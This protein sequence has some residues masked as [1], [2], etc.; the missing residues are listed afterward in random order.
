MFHRLGIAV[1]S[2]LFLVSAAAGETAA[3]KK[4]A[5]SRTAPPP[6]AA[7]AKIP[8]AERGWEAWAVADAEGGRVLAG[9]NLALR[10]PQ[11]SLTKVML[12]LVALDAVDRGEV[13]LEDAVRVTRRAEAM[14][15]SQVFLRAGEVFALEELLCAALVESANDAAM[16]VAEHVAG[17]AEAFVARM[18]RKA[19][20]LG[21]R[22]TEYHGVH[23]LPPAPGVPDN[24]STCAD[25]IRLACA[26]IARPKV[27]EWTGLA[28][29]P[30]RGG[31][32]QMRNKNRLV[33]RIPGVDG[34]K[35]GYT[36]RAGF[37]LIAT[38]TE[39]GR[40]LIVVVLGA[41]DPRRRDAFAVAKFNEFLHLEAREPGAPARPASGG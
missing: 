30:F 24:L 20:E 37:N 9:E 23:G 40:R 18:N 15:G 39:G 33:G 35:T 11:A 22:D 5:R 6:A 10:W 21:M 34:L 19:R 3:G 14:G 2:V 7:P 31:A 27:L 8:G 38:G 13:G 16:A 12:A 28:E 41:P 29:A 32:L 25:L 17:S 26:A 4:P 1:L 36:R